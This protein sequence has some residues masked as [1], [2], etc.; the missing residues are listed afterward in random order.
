MSIRQIIIAAVLCS[1]PPC[2]ATAGE[3]VVKGSFHTI[4][5]L[6]RNCLTVPQS[7]IYLRPG[8]R[9][10]MRSCQNSANQVFEW[11]VVTFEIKFHGL[12]MDAF[13]VEEDPS[14][15]GDPV[16]LWYCQKTQ[17]QKW[18]PYHKSERWLEAFNIVGGGSPSSDLCLNIVDDKNVD[19]ARLTIQKCDGGDNQWFRLY[20][21]PPLGGHLVSQRSNSISLIKALVA[22]A[23]QMRRQQNLDINRPLEAHRTQ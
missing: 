6:G 1:I 18:F 5:L 19:G 11:N 16:G 21:W 22:N 7:D 2:F 15:P 23:A 10:E 20:P 3:P 12:C 14:Q 9:L 17:H 13:R 4:F 8:A